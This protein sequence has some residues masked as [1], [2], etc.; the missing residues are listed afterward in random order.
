[1][2][3]FLD[4]YGVQDAKREKKVKAIAITLLLLLVSGVCLYFYF[5]NWKEEQIVKQFL[6]ALRGK[7][8]QTAYRFWGCT[9]EKPC[10]DYRLERFMEDWGPASPHS[11]LSSLKVAKSRSCDLVLI[12]T[13]DFGKGE[14]VNLTVDRRDLTLGFAPWPVCNPRMQAP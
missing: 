9:L 6:T 2:S 14:A 4:Q 11:D 7:D 3:A 13:L 10:R 12:Q 1:M 5:R 8:Y